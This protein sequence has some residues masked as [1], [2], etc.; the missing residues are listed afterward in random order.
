MIGNDLAAAVTER[1]ASIDD[2][3]FPGISIRDLGILENVRVD[4]ASGAVEIDLIPTFLGCPA[5]G[6][7]GDDVREAAAS[8]SGVSSVQV[9]FRSDPP[10][11]SSRISPAARRMLAD[12]FT[13]VVPP[14]ETETAACPV[15]GESTVEPVSPFGPTACRAIAYCTSCKNPVEVMK[16]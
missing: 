5:L 12:T 15:C 9:S 2:P 14:G 10:W 13:V 8:I 6:V 11:T 3:E 16:G 4:A 7:I 1:V